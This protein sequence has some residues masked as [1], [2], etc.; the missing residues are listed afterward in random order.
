M[1]SK[2]LKD[3]CSG[4]AICQPRNLHVREGSVSAFEL[5]QPYCADCFALQ[6][7][8]WV[9]ADCRSLQCTVVTL[10]FSMK[11]D[12]VMTCL[13]ALQSVLCNL[14][15]VQPQ[16]SIYGLSKDACLNP[17]RDGQALVEL[18][19]LVCAIVTKPNLSP[20]PTSPRSLPPHTIA[21]LLITSMAT[22]WSCFVNCVFKAAAFESCFYPTQIPIAPFIFKSFLLK[23][24]RLV[25]QQ[26][27]FCR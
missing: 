17:H 3:F 7:L 1:I 10:E 9:S 5:L 22:I 11:C 13:L 6:F 26:A 20:C 2:T 4:H 8:P 12:K 23:Q 16:S 21:L 19:F 24:F 15:L 14:A 18:A 27:M 25:P